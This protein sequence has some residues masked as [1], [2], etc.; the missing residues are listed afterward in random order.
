MRGNQ[1]LYLVTSAG[2][3]LWD[4]LVIALGCASQ[5]DYVDASTNPYLSAHRDASGLQA[6]RILVLLA[7]STSSVYTWQTT[8]YSFAPAGSV[9]GLLGVLQNLSQMRS[10]M[11]AMCMLCRCTAQVFTAGGTIPFQQHPAPSSDRHH[12]HSSGVRAT[13]PTEPPVPALQFAAL[14]AHHPSRCH[15]HTSL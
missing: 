1:L 8:Q 12:M 7:P 6:D 15:P 5:S 10:V 4:R 3:P 11:T 9:L 13:I 14:A 2:Y